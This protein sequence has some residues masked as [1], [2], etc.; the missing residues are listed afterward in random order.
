MEVTPT[1]APQEAEALKDAGKPSLSPAPPGLEPLDLKTLA[2]QEANI[3]LWKDFGYFLIHNK[4]WWLLPILLILILL[5]LLT[6]LSSTAVA[7]FIYT[8]F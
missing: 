5:S 3:P 4:K 1:H 7:P 2:E 6:A 8:V